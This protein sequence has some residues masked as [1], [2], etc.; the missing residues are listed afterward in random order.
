MIFVE[1]V[2]QLFLVKEEVYYGQS[3]I[4]KNVMGKT[5]FI[6]KQCFGIPEG[7]SRDSEMLLYN[8]VLPIVYLL[9]VC[10]KLEL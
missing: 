9:F 5:I 1:L 10:K 4:L 6:L 8:K 2:V 7:L 3:I